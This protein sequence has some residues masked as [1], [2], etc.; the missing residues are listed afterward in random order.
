MRRPRS[1]SP[2]YDPIDSDEYQELLV[3][4]TPEMAVQY[5]KENIRTQGG[6]YFSLPNPHYG[7]YENTIFHIRSDRFRD[8]AIPGQKGMEEP[9]NVTF[10][11]EMQSD[12]AIA[13]AQYGEFDL[14]TEIDLSSPRLERD[15]RNL[16]IVINDAIVRNPENKR[17]YEII[18][19]AELG[20]ISGGTGCDLRKHTTCLS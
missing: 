2:D 16:E 6:N 10:A 1:I 15:K 12:T 18:S 4:L 19:G 20:D 7:G 5:Q 3:G 9:K 13:K 8:N 17:T 11:E 14:N